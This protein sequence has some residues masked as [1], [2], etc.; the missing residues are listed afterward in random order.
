MV[1][2]MVRRKFVKGDAIAGIIIVIINLIFGMI[3]GMLQMGITFAEAATHFTILTV[4]DGIVS[5]NSG[6]T[7]FNCNRYCRNTSSIEWKS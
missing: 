4:G 6:I 3:I 2:W 1:R 5:S 7:Y